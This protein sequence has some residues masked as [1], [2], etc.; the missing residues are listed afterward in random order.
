MKLLVQIECNLEPLITFDR[1]AKK[2]EVAFDL[3]A[4]SDGEECDETERILRRDLRQRQDFAQPVNV[5][6][7]LEP[8]HDCLLAFRNIQETLELHHQM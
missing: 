6:L 5:V 4:V 1:S 7:L 8:A 3:S 2:I